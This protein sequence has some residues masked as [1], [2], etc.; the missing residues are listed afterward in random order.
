[1]FFENFAL[2]FLED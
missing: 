2:P 1:M